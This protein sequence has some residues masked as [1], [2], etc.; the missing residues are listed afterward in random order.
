MVSTVCLLNTELVL[1]HVDDFIDEPIHS[2]RA[3]DVILPRLLVHNVLSIHTIM[4]AV[5]CRCI[6]ATNCKGAYVSVRV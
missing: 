3:C 1:I 5:G 2:E 6:I 4:L